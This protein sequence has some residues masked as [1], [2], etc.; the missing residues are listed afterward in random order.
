MMRQ[1]PNFDGKVVQYFVGK[2]FP[3][4]SLLVVYLAGSLVPGLVV[5]QLAAGAAGCAWLAWNRDT[6]TPADCG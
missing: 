4:V 3:L 2:D 6:F 1:E 5:A